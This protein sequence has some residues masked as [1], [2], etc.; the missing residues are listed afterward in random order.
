MGPVREHEKQQVSTGVDSRGPA[1]TFR[2]GRTITTG[3][4]PDLLL[5]LDQLALARGLARSR[6]LAVL[7]DE[8]DDLDA[9][10]RRCPRRVGYT[11][12]TGVKR[13]TVSALILKERYQAIRAAARAA[14]VS[15][16]A[17]ATKIVED[18]VRADADAGRAAAS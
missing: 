8:V 7:I 9:L 11:P 18:A 10:A 15:V 13:K 12:P 14:D 16:A 3:L 17:M 6:M 2:N 1:V 4:V 5:G